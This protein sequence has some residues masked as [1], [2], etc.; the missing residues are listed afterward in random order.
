MCIRDRFRAQEKNC[1]KLRENSTKN[2]SASN[3]STWLIGY[4]ISLHRLFDLTDLK[5]KNC[6]CCLYRHNMH[7]SSPFSKMVLIFQNGPRFPIKSPFYYGAIP[8]VRLSLFEITS[9]CF[10]NEKVGRVDLKKHFWVTY[11]LNGPFS[12][13]QILGANSKT[14]CR[15]LI[16]LR[17]ITVI[18]QR[19]FILLNVV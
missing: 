12:G 18:Q 7:I 14:N 2:Y 1:A 6:W 15:I 3:S 19:Y 5:E 8:K 16:V 10:R 13:S 9:Y 4:H 17:F 11:F